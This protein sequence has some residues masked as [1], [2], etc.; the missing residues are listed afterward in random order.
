MQSLLYLKAKNFN[1]LKSWRIKQEKKLQLKNKNK[2]I[3][4]L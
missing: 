4:K 2:K 1:V 3:I